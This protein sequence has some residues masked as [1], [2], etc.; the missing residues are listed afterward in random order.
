MLTIDQAC[1]QVVYAYH[2]SVA[3]GSS[4]EEAVRFALFQVWMFNILQNDPELLKQFHEVAQ[5]KKA[6]EQP[7]EEPKKAPV[8]KKPLDRGK[9]VAL[10]QAGWGLQKIADELGTS[11]STVSRV[12]IE[13]AVKQEGE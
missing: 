2:Q 9:I 3:N 4:R 11:V 7:K 10:R 1:A 13:D 5:A 8:K 6:E 12:C